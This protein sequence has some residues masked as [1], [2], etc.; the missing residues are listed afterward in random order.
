M[1]EPQA[2]ADGKATNRGLGFIVETRERLRVSH[3]GKQGETTTRLVI[4]PRERHG[5]V[6]MC[7]CDF[8][9]VGKLSTAVY[10]A[11]AGK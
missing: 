1:W 4:Y 5:V 6:V 9:D 11:L 10:S 2:T 8:A 7:N 3:N